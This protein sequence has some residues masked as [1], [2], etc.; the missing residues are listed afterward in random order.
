MT[1]SRFCV[2]FVALTVLLGSAAV[3]QQKKAGK[4]AEEKLKDNYELMRMFA[5]TFEQI[6][7]NYVKD[8][9]RRELM[10]AAIQGM[11]RRLDQYSTY[12]PRQYIDDF[13]QSVEQ[14][15]GGIGIQVGVNA[16]RE[17]TVITPL[18]GGPAY[19]AGVRA[20][21]TILEING[22]SAVGFTTNDAILKLKGPRGGEVSIGVRRADAKRGDPL[23]TITLV[24]DIIELDTVK[25]DSFHDGKW[26]FM[27]DKERKIGYIRLTHFSRKS[28]EELR[29][30]LDTL[31]EDGM[32]GLVLDLRNNP[33]G[34]LSQATRIADM[35]VEDGLIVS[36][37]GRNVPEQ[38]WKAE[39]AGTYSGFP[40]AVLV[41]RV[42]ASASE[43]VA[44]CLQD[45]KR[46]TIVGERSWGKG[47]V[48]N[49]IDLEQGQSALKLTT[50]S[51]FRP[52]GRNIH[53]FPD[54]KPTDEWGVSPDEGY[55]VKFSR[56]ERF[57]WMRARQDG[58]IIREG[59]Q[60]DTTETPAFVDRQLQK[61]IEV[62]AG[63][64]ASTDAK[65]EDED[66]PEP[67]AQSGE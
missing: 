63:T 60:P 30:A 4:S 22:E 21:D 62:V 42:S 32:K 25:G 2:P 45:H 28:S 50:A 11:V 17:L 3:A 6:D 44:A 43:I 19:F 7:Q 67:P 41:N 1:V 10:E 53:R 55:E 65:E 13:N 20:G 15:Y 12:I 31:R 37:K 14:E 54:S 58:D 57:K 51:Y 18:P 35:F 27:L 34:L 66:K 16:N 23:E 56:E 40:M 9:D 61:A 36:T 52:S 46:A 8:V 26:D 39:K 33:G 64:D 59:D 38:S 47:S 49:V 24:R 29:L 5:E 48:Q